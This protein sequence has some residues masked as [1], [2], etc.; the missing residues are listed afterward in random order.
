MQWKNLGVLNP[1][2]NK[3]MLYASLLIIFSLTGCPKVKPD[4]WICKFIKLDPIE[5]SYNF[6]VNAK[7]KAELRIPL[8]A[9]DTCIEKGGDC[10]WITT[11]QDS[12]DKIRKAVMEQSKNEQ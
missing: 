3:K 8:E 9:M 6:C 10:A 1:S 2:K 11:D 4:A 7:S 12:F 5:A